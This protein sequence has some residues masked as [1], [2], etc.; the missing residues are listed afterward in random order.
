M[1]GSDGERWVAR[2]PFSVGGLGPSK[3]PYVLL[4][5]AAAMALGLFLFSGDKKKTTRR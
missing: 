3:T 2:F 1:E 4:A 5:L